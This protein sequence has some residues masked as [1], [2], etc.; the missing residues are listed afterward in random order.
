MRR[1]HRE[2]RVLSYE[3]RQES[4]AIHLQSLVHVPFAQVVNESHEVTE[5]LTR[6]KHHEPSVLY[7]FIQS[8][9]EL[10]I[11]G[12][13]YRLILLVGWLAWG[14]QLQDYHE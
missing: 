3:V 9:I 12:I 5:P 11:F 13:H 6:R 10:F 14:G 4:L 7:Q 8:A 2:V 1:L